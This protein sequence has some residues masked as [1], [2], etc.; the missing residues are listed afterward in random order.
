MQQRRNIETA[1]NH[2]P[3]QKNNGKTFQQ[4][5]WGPKEDGWWSLVV[6]DEL[7][8][9]PE[10]VV[11]S[12]TNAEENIEAFNNIFARHGCFQ[13]LKTD[14]GPPFNGKENHLFERYFKWAA[15]EH[16][17]VK[18][19][20]DPEANGLAEVFMKLCK[21]A[22]LTALIER[23]NHRAEIKEALKLYRAT[24]DQSMEFTPAKV[25]FRRTFPT[26]LTQL[27][28]PAHRE[29]VDKARNKD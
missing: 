2:Q 7:S 12:N 16:N 1:W 21:K 18:S 27:P 9:Y 8:R 13:R 5:H 3:H 23:N 6:V 24:T 19:A 29:D 15:I 17:P 14:N 4:N 20:G 10:I 25:L 26:L 22:L 11:V 28:Q